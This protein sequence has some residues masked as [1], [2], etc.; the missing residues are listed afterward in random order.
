MLVFKIV[1]SHQCILKPEGLPQVRIF[2]IQDANLKSSSFQSNQF[3]NLFP[4]KKKMI[5][6]SHLGTLKIL[7]NL[8]FQQMIQDNWIYLVSPKDVQLRR[9][10]IL[11][12]FLNASLIG[13]LCSL[14]GDKLRDK[15]I[16]S[17]YSITSL[18]NKVVII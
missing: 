10:D 8:D 17:I 13:Q 15:V 16:Y 7:D 6:E 5:V 12:V 3:S 1:G 14:L 2:V 18:N 4:Q 11:S 9:T